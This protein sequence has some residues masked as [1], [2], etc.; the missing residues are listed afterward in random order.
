[1]NLKYLFFRKQLLIMRTE[2][3]LY[4]ID[5]VRK[6]REELGL[7]QE[8]LSYTLGYSSTF[9]SIRES[10]TKKYNVDHL[11]KLAKAL[12]CSPREFLPEAAI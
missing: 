3:D 7:S 5:R 11:N 4:V 8:A 6:R 1:M 2:F 12:K 9:I 10:G